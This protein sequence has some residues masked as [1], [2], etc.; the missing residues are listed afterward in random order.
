MNPSSISG[1]GRFVPNDGTAEIVEPT[2]RSLHNISSAVSP[3]SAAV[4]SRRLLTTFA[5][6][7]DQFDATV[8]VESLAQRIAISSPI[9]NQMLRNFVANLNSI[10]GWLNELDLAVV[11]AGQVDGERCAVRVNDVDHF[12]ALATFGVAN[13]VAPFF[14][15]ANQASAAASFQSIFP[16]SSSSVRS[17]NHSPSK[18]PIRV[19]SSKRR[20][21]V[22]GEGKTFGNF[23]HWH[24]VI[25]T[26]KIP[27]KQARAE[28]NGRP[29]RGCSS[30]S[31]IM[32]EMR[33]HCASERYVYPVSSIFRVQAMSETPFARSGTQ[34]PCQYP[35]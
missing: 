3:T 32:Y 23:D 8:I 27:S 18:I 28:W 33:S 22:L 25:S 16:R 13:S 9:V 11:C 26:Y 29:P 14:A 34:F 35:L 17:S 5:M 2:V 20:Q 12:R 15:R 7:A 6:G 4:L 30:G 10:Q 31:G 19:H 1:Q 24:P 21:H